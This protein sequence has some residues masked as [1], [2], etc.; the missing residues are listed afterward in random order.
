MIIGLYLSFINPRK[1]VFYLDNTRYQY[2][3]AEKF[4]IVDIFFHILVF[5]FICNRYAGYYTDM[6]ITDMKNIYAVLLII[7]Y[8]SI[9]NI[10]KVYGVA[11]IE[12][13]YVFIAANILYI[14]LFT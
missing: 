13:L 11:F 7:G 3:G 1:F 9:T 5:V 8:V 14:L 10:K 2:T 6:N 4:I 12:L